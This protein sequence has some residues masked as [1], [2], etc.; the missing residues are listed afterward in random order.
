LNQI[1][2]PPCSRGLR[3]SLV[4][5]MPRR[6]QKLYRYEINRPWGYSLL[7]APFDVPVYRDSISSREMRDSLEATFLPVFNRNDNA[8]KPIFDVLSKMHS[9]SAE[10]RSALRSTLMRIYRDGIVSPETFEEL[11]KNN[12][13]EVRFVE[14][15]Q[16]VRSSATQFK[17]PRQAYAVIDSMFADP[18][19]RKS[20]GNMRLASLVEP[21]IILDTAATRQL[22]EE[23]IQP[24]NAA[25]DVI[26][27]GERIIDR[28]DRVTP[29]L[30]E[31]LNTYEQMMKTRDF[32]SNRGD[33]F[34]NLGQILFAILIFSALYCYLFLFRKKIWKDVKGLTAIIALLIAIYVVAA[35]V[36]PHLSNGIWLVPF[37]ILPVV[38]VVLY[39]ARTG[40][41][42][43]VLEILLCATF[44]SST[45]EFI[46]LQA[47]AGMVSIYTL[48]ELTKRS[49]LLRTAAAV[50]MVYVIGFIAVELMHTGTLSSNVG[51]I[52]GYF[53]I[54]SVLISFAYILIFVVEKLFGLTSLVTLVE[55]CDINN[56]L[57]RELSEQCPGTFQHSMSV[58][59]LAGDAARKINANPLIVRAGALYHDIGKVSN[60]AFFTEN[61]HGVN[62][63]DALPPEQSARIIIGH[64]L[65]GKKLAEKDKLPSVLHDMILQHHGRGLA[66]YFYTMAQRQQPDSTVNT[67]PFTYPG[68]NPQTIEASLLMMADAVEAAS[69]SLPEHTIESIT[70]LV[71]KIIDG[72]VD[73]GLHRESPIS[74]RD[75]QT[76]KE[77]FIN[78]LRTIYHVRIAYPKQ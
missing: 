15:N 67:E 47:M 35:I 71:N 9:I 2:Y 74:F 72:Q 52:I 50:F 34:I 42:C 27:K 77:S 8:S 7:T 64:V 29:Q 19:L 75:I 10:D 61:Q 49:Q 51:R 45:F 31:I 48:R 78:R 43:H 55:L 39:D 73:A 21:N 23:R 18:E 62:P 28:G 1:Q 17:T 32:T 12:R 66:K 22:F 30:Y 25:I 36:A 4:L 33:F 70:E 57:L 46:F 60:P 65:E 76:I 16:L 6:D 40:F 3:F 58:S 5:L 11:K 63:H 13:T 53:A 44:V 24:V 37:V 26:Q 20:I 38:I 69:R 41:Y 14:G 54:N 59:N 68:P 56:P